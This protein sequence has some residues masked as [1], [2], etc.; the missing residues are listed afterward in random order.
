MFYQHGFQCTNGLA[1]SLLQGVSIDIHGGAGLSVAQ[2]GGHGAHVLFAGDQQ[3]G[4]S[5]AQTMEGNGRQLLVWLLI[6]VVPGYGVLKCGIWGGVGHLLSVVLDE[7]PFGSLPVVSDSQPVLLLR[8][9]YET[10][11]QKKG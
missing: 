3:R 1:V 2:S 8:M 10:I 9:H 4:G 11:I 5:V 6:C 7:Q